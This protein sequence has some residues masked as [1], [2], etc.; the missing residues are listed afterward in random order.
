MKE[1]RIRNLLKSD[2]PSIGT[3][4]WS[5]WPFITE[6]IGAAGNF[7]YI[8]FL[9]EYAPFSH[10]D[11]EN[12][13]RAAELHGMGSMIKVDFQNRFYVAQKAIAS[14]FQ[15][16]L[17]ADHKTPDEVRESVRM[18]KADSPASSGQFGYPSRRY[19]GFQPE[20][21]QLEHAR[22]ID[23][24]VLVFMIEKSEALDNIEEICSIPG[25][26]MVQFGSSDYSMSLGWNE[27]EHVE[28]WMAA[29]RK[30][31]EVALKHGVHP[32]CE[33]FGSPEDAEY[34]INLGVRH[35]CFGD[36]FGNNFNF[37]KNEG[38]KMRKI[39]DCIKG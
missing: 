26:D 20:E 30:M 18:V 23:D 15:A 35:F 34:Y 13:C 28:E 33:I 31:I 32:R 29:E 7:D 39:T 1:N 19:I 27:A 10:Y 4:I 2:K 16:I 21:N 11:L 36:E 17:F 6:A 25:V 5:S 38:A 9:A 8:E 12:I 22:Q 3:R 24:V 37:W 14:G